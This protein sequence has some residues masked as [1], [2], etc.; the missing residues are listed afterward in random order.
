M[1]VPADDIEYLS[2]K[3]DD[4]QEQTQQAA[5]PPAPVDAD[6]FMNIP[7]GIDEE[8]PFC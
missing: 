1:E 3:S 2:S 6:G 5:P 8:L 7:P 4:Q